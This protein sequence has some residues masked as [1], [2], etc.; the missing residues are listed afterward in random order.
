MGYCGVNCHESCEELVKPA[1][2]VCG[3]LAQ[4]YISLLSANVLSFK[5]L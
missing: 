2:R 4:N 5:T 3:H 1:V